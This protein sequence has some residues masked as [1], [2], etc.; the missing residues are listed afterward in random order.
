MNAADKAV[1]SKIRALLVVFV[2]NPTRFT[3]WES[4]TLAKLHRNSRAQTDGTPIYSSTEAR[5]VSVLHGR[6][7]R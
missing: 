4:S 7:V 2:A 5:W 6:I 3:E 1:V